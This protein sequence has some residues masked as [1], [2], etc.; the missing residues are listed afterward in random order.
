VTLVVPRNENR[1]FFPVIPPFGV[2]EK[3]YLALSAYLPGCPRRG[4]EETS[5]GQCVFMLLRFVVYFAS[6]G[7]TIGKHMTRMTDTTP[8]A[9][10]GARR[11]RRSVAA[12]GAATAALTVLGG[13]AAADGIFPPDAVPRTVSDPDRSS[14]ELGVRF[15]SSVD[16]TITGISFYKGERNSGTHTATL[17]SAAGERIATATFTGESAS[18]W[19]EA[20]FAEPVAIL[21]GTTYVASYLSPRGRYSVDEFGFS[22]SRTSGPLTVPAGGGVYSYDA[23][24]FPDET[25]LDSNYYV[26]VEFTAAGDE[27]P[28]VPVPPVVTPPVPTPPTPA[29]PVT[30]PAPV[31]SVLDLPVIPWEGGPDYWKQFSKAD[32][33]GWDDPS[34][35][36]VVAWFNGI[37]SDEEVQYDKSVGIN[38]YVGMWEG[39]PY[40]L[41]DDNDVYFIG[42][43]L[44]SSFDAD[45]TNWVGDFLG[46][47]I[48]GRYS[49]SEGHAVMAE[50]DAANDGT[51]RFDYSNFTQIVTSTDGD[52]AS[53]SRYVNDYTDVASVDM[54]WYTI[55]FCDWTDPYR[56]GVYLE[57]VLESNCRTSSS[58]GKTMDALRER[59][60]ADGELQPLWQFVENL[61]GGPGPSAPAVYIQPGQLKGAVMNSII[62]EAR[63][64][65]YFNQSLSGGCQGGSIVRQSQGDP[66]FCGAEQVQAMTEVDGQVRALAPVINTQSYSW[67]FGTGLDTMLKA[68]DGSAYVFAMIDG[69]SKPGSRTLQL[70]AGVTG[71]S[72]EVVGEN[73]T[74]AVAAD[75][76]FTDSF[77]AEYSYHTYKVAL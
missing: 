3:I 19:Q 30:E 20:E 2:Q 56:G 7:Q 16:G 9:H 36:P 44:N 32:A 70:P 63:G 57:P 33:A 38:T 72:V 48:D 22:R 58:Y 24:S 11:N 69:A 65:V 25:Y 13:P 73:R 29:P 66:G 10:R 76:S 67:D 53:A 55:P 8:T 42:D 12:I 14:V 60:A 17:W 71:T 49:V 68:Y 41:F 52:Q 61:N 23:G 62:N 75:G 18:G 46:D 31:G 15:S 50:A 43:K 4:G 54:Y 74:I 47:E 34:F 40:S 51:G 6:G 1:E 21:A 5:R 28:T 26:D 39:T 64:I 45:A 77:A 37:S 35:F 59:D 27:S